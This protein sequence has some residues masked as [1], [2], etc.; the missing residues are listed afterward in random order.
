MLRVADS[1]SDRVLHQ[2]KQ[3]HS[4]K[5]AQQVVSFR[6]SKYVLLVCAVLVDYY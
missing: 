1:K 4:S 2:N 5:A 6:V 3:V